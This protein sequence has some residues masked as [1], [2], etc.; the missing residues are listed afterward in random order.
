MLDRREDRA[1][2]AGSR[3]FIA[4]VRIQLIELARLAVGPPTQIAGPG[5]PQIRM[6]DFLETTRCVE[7]RGELV[8][9][10]LIVHK[11]V[12]MRRVDRSFIKLL[13]IERAAFDARDFRRYQSG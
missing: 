4:E 7:A 3:L 12:R 11:T 1:R 9:E 8:G 13:C 2:P 5:V 10:R 6:R